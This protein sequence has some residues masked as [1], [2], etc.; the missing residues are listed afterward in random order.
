MGVIAAGVG[1]VLLGQ[2]VCTGQ[3]VYIEDAFIYSGTMFIWGRGRTSATEYIEGRFK[4]GQ[5]RS[6]GRN[7]YTQTVEVHTRA[8][9]TGAG[10]VCIFG[11]RGRMYT[12]I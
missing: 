4:R 6:G 5:V 8:G 2:N 10:T 9:H 7:V 1:S 3:V 12:Q 11:G